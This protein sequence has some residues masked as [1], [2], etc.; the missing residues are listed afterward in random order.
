MRLK[1]RFF[2]VKLKLI[3]R[4][5]VVPLKSHDPSLGSLQPD[6]ANPS[7]VWPIGIHAEASSSEE[8]KG[9]RLTTPPVAKLLTAA[10]RASSE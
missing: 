7:T 4:P 10:A 6:S 2:P 5:V 9:A 8:P 1:F 3:V